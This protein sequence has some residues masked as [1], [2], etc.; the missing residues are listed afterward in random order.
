MENKLL[1]LAVVLHDK[2]G[3]DNLSVTRLSYN[4]TQRVAFITETERT[5][6]STPREVI[7]A[8]KK[9]VDKI[10]K[11]KAYCITV[12]GKT[13][14]YAWI[15][16]NILFWDDNVFSL[17]LF[18]ELH[19][20]VF[21]G[22]MITPDSKPFDANKSNIDTFWYP[23]GVELNEE[24]VQKVASRFALSMLG[25][26]PWKAKFMHTSTKDDNF[27]PNR[28]LHDVNW[29]SIFWR[30]FC[31][32]Y[33]NG[34][35]CIKTHRDVAHPAYSD[36]IAVYMQDRLFPNEAPNLVSAHFAEKK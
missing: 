25:S 11:K 30:E 20:R 19:S 13:P 6:P 2:E 24:V 21:R 8:T 17:E 32:S 33:W 14:A 10:A 31:K 7:R 4:F 34:N 27:L 5:K 1:W 29:R 3:K 18:W 16:D 36:V 15:P 28:I 23:T 35:M 26:R 22:D 12:L 9:M